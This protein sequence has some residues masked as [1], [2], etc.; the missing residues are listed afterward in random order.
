LSLFSAMAEI[1][2]RDKYY[3][4]AV[5]FIVYKQV[6]YNNYA[7]AN[8]VVFYVSNSKIWITGLLIILYVIAIIK[9]LKELLLEF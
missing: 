8:D 2:W 5:N 1:V 4:D 9:K 3:S 7:N 6:A